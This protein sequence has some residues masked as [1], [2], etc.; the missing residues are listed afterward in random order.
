MRDLILWDMLSLD[1]YFESPGG[2]IDWFSFDEELEQHILQTQRTAGTLVFGRKT[3]E[4]M[5][6][7]WPSAEGE[8]AE[9]M[10]AV[11]KVV[12]ST[13]LDKATWNNSRVAARDVPGEISKLKREPGGDIF[14]FGSAGLSAALIEHG[15]VD[16]YR[17]AINPILLGAGTPFFKGRSARLPLT[18]V[19]SKPLRS[20]LVI[21]H[22][23]PAVGSTSRR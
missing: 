16:E 10:N 3:Y 22:Y 4:G 8:I 18:L 20:G 2:G 13:T 9:F 5:A 21:L 19:E 1:G 6:A 23:R 11:P 14:V 7:Y 17:V 12:F 15:L